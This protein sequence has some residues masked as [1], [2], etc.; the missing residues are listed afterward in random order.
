MLYNIDFDIAA[1]AISLFIII[2]IF[3]KKGL[4]NTANRFF[5][6]LVVSNLFA[7]TADII[8]AILNPVTNS[9]QLIMADLANGIYLWLHNSMTPLLFLYILSLLGEYQRMSWGKRALICAPVFLD[10]VL[11][12]LNPLFRFVYYFDAKGIYRHGYLFPY[13][14]AAAFGYM[15]ASVFLLISRRK[16]IRKSKRYALI[17]IITATIISLA[18]QIAYP[19]ILIEIFAQTMGF[20][21]ILLSIE[22]QDEITNQIS[23]AYNRYA[24]IGTAP[25][26]LGNKDC[27]FIV[28]KLQE[29]SYYNT[30]IGVARTNEYL[31][32]IASYLSARSHRL[33]CYDLGGGNFVLLGRGIGPER[34]SRLI[35]EIARRF[36]KPWSQDETGIQF[37]AMICGGGADRFSSMEELLL[38]VDMSFGG[39]ETVIV[40]MGEIAEKHKRRILIE[41]LIKDALRTKSFQVYYQPIW[42]RESGQFRSAE[43]LIRLY[44][45][46]YGFI[47]PEEF[48]PIAEKGGMIIEIGDFV[49]DEVCRFY[50]S[51]E[52]NKLGIEYVEVNL[53]TVQ[54]MDPELVSNFKKTLQRYE[55]QSDRINLEITESA[56]ADNRRVLKDN[57][58]VLNGLG[59]S[60]SLD[61]YGTGYSN[62]SYMF[63]LPFSI[64]KLDKSILWRAL[65]PVKGEGAKSS[66]ILLVNTIRMM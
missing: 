33:S 37:P 51:H 22:N 28:V 24:F 49:F 61:D 57:V 12:L 23:K 7:S 5:L 25:A 64:I 42:E 66:R 21:G 47:S 6:A 1:I 18:V 31:Q 2:Y 50:K 59:F 62:F 27:I 35:D 13:F 40:D 14:Y 56:A 19:Y 45:K 58:S 43:A 54:C 20:L 11:L 16:N 8:G 55:I 44:T 39:N 60:F 10:Y 52:L 46:D 17:F 32:Q 65:H 9:A 38:I 36:R 26:V 29:L 15:V 3:S 4:K 53:S 30:T 34:L 48:I 41:S 63:D